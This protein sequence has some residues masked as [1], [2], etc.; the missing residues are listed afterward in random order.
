MCDLL[1]VPGWNFNGKTFTVG[2]NGQ[3]QSGTDL[4]QLENA[5]KTMSKQMGKSALTGDGSL[6]PMEEQ[7]ARIT[8]R[9]SGIK[10]ASIQA[11]M[12]TNIFG[13]AGMALLPM[14]QAE[15][16]DK[17]KSLTKK[18]AVKRAEKKPLHLLPHQ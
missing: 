4:S 17:W 3:E 2:N 10:N 14:L 9:L 18:A 8:Q 6:L 15:A 16:R 5:M 13:K 12:A 7:F 11:A 1:A